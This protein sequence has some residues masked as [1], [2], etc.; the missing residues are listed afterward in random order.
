MTIR[1]FRKGDAIFVSKII[2][3]CF[4]R[5]NLGGYSDNVINGQIKDNSPD[6][7]LEYSNNVK[8]FVAVKD[9]EIIG[10]A[11]Y[12]G[13]KVRTLFV[14]I[15]YQNNG[16]GKKL[17]AKILS[18]ANKDRINKLLCWSTLFAEKFYKNNGFRTNKNLR[19]PYKNDILTFKEMQIIL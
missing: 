4:K 15:S 3:E 13:A 1:K 18:E 8:Y 5:Q 11:G 19:F 14:K 7:I 16:I 10:I 12:D 6:K 2:E 17:L 9:K